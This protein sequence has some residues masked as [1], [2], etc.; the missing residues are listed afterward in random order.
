MQLTLYTDYTLRVL[1]YLA[2]HRGR[3]V[4]ITEVAQYYGISRNHLVKVVHNLSTLGYIQTARGKGGG[5]RLDADPARVSIG[6]V[7]RKVEPHF[8]IVE[9]FN[10]KAPKCT[11]EPLCALKNALWDAKNQ[12]LAAL[13]GI[14]LSK[15]VR[16]DGPIPL[17]FHP[18]PR[19][20]RETR[21]K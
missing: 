10:S 15:A 7:V 8:D 11:V 4:T 9:C 2:M 17:V 19:P 20:T 6:E 13:D 5:I 18:S 12:F 14:T 16:Q 3:T 21:R 1:I